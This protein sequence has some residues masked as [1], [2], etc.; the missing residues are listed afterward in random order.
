VNFG[1]RAASREPRAALITGA[2]VRVGRAIALGLADAGFRVVVHYGRSQDEAERVVREIRDSGGEA[3]A[4][5]ADLRDL[6]EVERLA[7]EADAAFGGVD[8][9]VNNAATFAGEGIG[10]VSP[11]IWSSALDTNLRAPFF[12][13][14]HLAEGMRAR[15]GGV[16]INIADLSGVQAWSGH[17][18]HGIAKAGLVHFTRI[19]ARQLGPEVRVNA[20]APGTVL[21]PEGTS[22]DEIDR[23]ARGSALQ[24]IGNPADV[25]EAVLYLVRAD[26]VT[27]QL[28]AVDGGRLVRD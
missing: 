19:A 13:T 6:G 14:Q 15:G 26:F 25:V 27:G 4:V 17:A 24:R 3:V 18:A 12:L 5:Q 16:V 21:P 23:L 10:E 28:L 1:W 2:G 8:V 22:E 20:I 7:K 11:E 9:L